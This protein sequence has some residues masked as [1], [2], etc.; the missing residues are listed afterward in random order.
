MKLVTDKTFDKE[1][2]QN[3]KPVLV[4]FYTTWCGPCKLQT[5]VLETL[6][7]EM[8]DV[9]FTKVNAEDSKVAD[10]YNVRSVPTLIIFKDG[11]EI[12]RKEAFTTK[13]TLEKWLA[14]S[15]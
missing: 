7:V 12:S 9:V 6:S 8:E 15:I 5:P 1:V 11:K 2:I 14:D 13:A 10:K 4:D 3:E